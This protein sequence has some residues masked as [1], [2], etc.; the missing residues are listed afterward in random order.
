MA[1][2][3]RVSG[4]LTGPLSESDVVV[5]PVVKVDESFSIAAGVESA[6]AELDC[7]ADIDAE[8]AKRQGFDAKGGEL[9]IR[10][11]VTSP[12]PTGKLPAH[13]NLN[14]EVGSDGSVHVI[15]PLGA[16]TN[17]PAH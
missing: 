7:S 5:V 11:T 15:P 1:S 14:V 12:P 4:D 3:L 17:A 6:L 2:T 16:A 13:Y 10:H 8:Y 9:L